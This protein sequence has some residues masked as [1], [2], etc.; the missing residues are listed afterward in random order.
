MY[1]VILA[2]AS[3][4][5]ANFESNYLVTLRMNGSFSIFAIRQSAYVTLNNFAVS[6]LTATLT[7][8]QSTGG[9]Y[10]NGNAKVVTV[11]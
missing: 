2:W 9:G 10:T 11:C 7:I 5:D 6:G 4:A 1:L 3:G 8:S